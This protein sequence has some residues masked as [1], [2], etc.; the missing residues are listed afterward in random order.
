MHHSI[1][2]TSSNAISL[3]SRN[4]VKN[5]T[6][7]RTAR[8][9]RL[10]VPTESILIPSGS[11]YTN[12]SPIVPPE[13]KRHT[14]RDLLH[15]R[16]IAHRVDVICRYVYPTSNKIHLIYLI[17]QNPQSEWKIL[18]DRTDFPRKIRE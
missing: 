5:A 13:A 1:G 6:L 12:R 10:F 9:F 4:Q 15:N 7:L 2:Y 14:H 3:F 16:T 11:L 17:L 18:R 8:H